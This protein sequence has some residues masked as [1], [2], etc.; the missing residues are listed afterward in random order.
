MM[1]KGHPL[2]QGLYHDSSTVAPN[3]RKLFLAFWTQH[4]PAAELGNVR[5]IRY[6]LLKAVKPKTRQFT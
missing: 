2:P 6:L 5:G 4:A 3:K 1:A